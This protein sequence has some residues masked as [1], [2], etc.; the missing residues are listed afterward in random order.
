M[1]DSRL[2]RITEIAT[3]LRHSIVITP[4]EERPIGLRD[5]PD[6]SCGDTALLL[7]TMLSEAG[8]GEFCYVSAVRG[9]MGNH[10]Y[11]SHAWIEQNS[12]IIDITADQFPEIDGP[13]IVTNESPWHA[14]FEIKQRHAARIDALVGPSL[15]ALRQYHNSIRQKIMIRVEDSPFSETK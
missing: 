10:T 8:F 15:P 3:A 9:D 11:R 2:Q 6:G 7:G 14:S 12:L 4:R 5:F 13:V 1:A